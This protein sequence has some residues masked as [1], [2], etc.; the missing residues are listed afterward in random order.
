MKEWIW[1]W[2]PAVVVMIVIFFASATPSSDLP[3]FGT[4]D[5]FAKKSGHMFGYGLLAAA[6]SHALKKGGKIMKIQFIAAV[7]LACLYAVSDEFHQSFTPG[8]SPSI[9]DVGIDA[10]GAALGLLIWN[11]IRKLH[12]AVDSRQ[13]A[14]GRE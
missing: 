11:W 5:L 9:Q 13:S 4:W 6:F 2:G 7:C 14:V 1:R 3:S 12:K 8:R 10:I